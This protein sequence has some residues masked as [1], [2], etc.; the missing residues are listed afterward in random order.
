MTCIL[1]A[2]QYREQGSGYDMFCML[3]LLFFLRIKSAGFWCC[4]E[5]TRSR[6]TV[7]CSVP[8]LLPAF[9]SFSITVGRSTK[10]VCVC[11][12][13]FLSVCESVC[14]CCCL[15][16]WVY[17][18]VFC[19]YVTQMNSWARARVFCPAWCAGD[20]LLSVLLLCCLM[21]KSVA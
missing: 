12:C 7:S 15:C 10:T 8:I 19:S 21:H 13:V 11:V 6:T 16:V 20:P 3:F 9:T 4:A 17:L 2:A 1:S 5:D 18:C 14:I